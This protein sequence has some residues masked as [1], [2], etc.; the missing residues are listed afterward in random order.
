L[1]AGTGVLFGR[2]AA[3]ALASL[4][5]AVLALLFRLPVG[6]LAAFTP[7]FGVLLGGACP[8]TTAVAA[9]LRALAAAPAGLG[10]FLLISLV[11]RAFLMGGP[12]AHAGDRALFLFV[13]GGKTTGLFLS[14]ETTPPLTVSIRSLGMGSGNTTTAVH[15]SRS[16]S[17][18]G[19]VSS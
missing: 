9:A 16:N 13:H 12:I 4:A 1:A 14:H 6:G 10:R 7:G 3:G 19:F 17:S 2:A 5:A 15:H 11:R 18:T 8:R